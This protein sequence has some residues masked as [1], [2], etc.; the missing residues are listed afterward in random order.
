MGHAILVDAAGCATNQLPR[1]MHAESKAIRHAMLID[2]YYFGSWIFAQQVVQWP[3]CGIEYAFGYFV[4][5][6]DEKAAG[7]HTDRK[8]LF[9]RIDCVIE[10][11]LPR[12]PNAFARSRAA[13][14]SCAGCSARKGSPGS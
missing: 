6:C 2:R 10:R 14:G 11:R 9:V 7:V 12:Y 13:A 3:F 1:T 4:N 8:W 5:M